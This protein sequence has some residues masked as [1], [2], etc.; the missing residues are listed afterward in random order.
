MLRIDDHTLME[1]FKEDVPYFDLTTSLQEQSSKSV[2]LEIFTREDVI[3]SC[4]EEAKRVAELLGCDIEY[5][6][7]SKQ[8]ARKGETLLIMSGTYETVHQVWRSVQNILEYSCKIAT[9]THE[10]K[11]A[12]ISENPHCELLTTRKNFPFAK[13]FCIRSVINGGAMPHRL[14]LGETVIFFPHHRIVYPSTEAFYE[15]IA[16]LK[17]KA[18]EKKI[19]IESD[20]FEE[21]MV[22]M[23]KGADVIQMDKVDVMTLQKLTEYRDQH[24]AE[25][26][27]LASGGVNRENAQLFA[28]T[29]VD[30]IVTSAVYF[31]G[32][33][34]MGSK[35]TLL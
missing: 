16:M 9:Y 29:R 33:A 31:C 24:F 2:R 21:A 19:V 18:P 11:E 26:K 27:I 30:G 10:M 34:N 20:T 14:G 13:S 25:V 22:L 23:Q 8:K 32:M 17:K 1:Y 28:K 5:W 12:I 35:M 6:I 7:P 3:V 4:S 15:E